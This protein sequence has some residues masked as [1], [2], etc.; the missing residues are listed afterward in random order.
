MDIDKF[1]KSLSIDNVNNMRYMDVYGGISMISFIIIIV[2]IFRMIYTNIKLNAIDLR[3]DWKNIRCKPQYIP[4]AGIINPVEGKTLFG[5]SVSNFSFCLDGV[6]NSII[7][8]FLAPIY[9]SMEGINTII[10]NVVETL[11]NVRKKLFDSVKNILGVFNEVFGVVRAFL[12][13]LQELLVRT[14]DS[15]HKMMAVAV[16]SLFTLIS[17][18]YTSLSFFRNYLKTMVKGMAI[19][20]GVIAG[21]IAFPFTAPYGLTLLGVLTPIYVLMGAISITI[22]QILGEQVQILPRLPKACF[23]GATT[24]LLEDGTYKEIHMIQPGD[25]LYYDGRVNSIIQ[26]DSKEQQMYYLPDYKIYV[27]GTHEMILNNKWYTISEIYNQ[28]H[29]LKQQ[30]YVQKC[31]DIEH[32]K[33]KSQYIYCLNTESG[34]IRLNNIETNNDIL[35]FSDWNDIEPYEYSQLTKN[36]IYTV[37]KQTHIHKYFEGGFIHYTPITLNS[38]EITH[39]NRLKIGDILSCGST[40]KGIV[41]IYGNDLDV[42]VHKILDTEIIGL[43]NNIIRCDNPYS[44]DVNKKIKKHSVSLHGFKKRKYTETDSQPLYHIITDTHTFN[45][46]KITFYDYYACTENYLDIFKNTY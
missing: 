43:H 27:S 42:Y 26:I 1:L 45:I 16:T 19:S 35:V 30:L 11:D 15:L 13:P 7:K 21:L 32:N 46:D 14:K 6:L 28:Q 33:Y 29:S 3:K 24:F 2:V 41:E 34:Y 10:N 5:Q 38:G 22:A 17:S 20:I 18:Y 40:V 4:F 8:I 25:V 39:I 44:D 9:S 23:G 37:T 12:I 31:D 36:S